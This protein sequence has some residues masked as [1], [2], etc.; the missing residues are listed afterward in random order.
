MSIMI[1]SRVPKPL[2][3]TALCVYHWLSPIIDPIRV[4]K[5]GKGCLRYF[6]D[7]Y[8][9]SRLLNAE[10]IRLVDTYPQVHDHTDAHG[11]DAH[12]F[13]TNG[14]AI[15][16][17]I[18]APP[19][20]HVDIASQVVFANLLSAVMPVVFVDFRPLEAKLTGLQC[21]A[22]S[23]LSLPFAD[24]SI[25]SL[26]CLHVIE[27]VGLG[28]Y[29]DALDPQGTQKAA[30]ELSRI[31]APEGHMFLTTPVG[32]PRLCFNA[33]RIHSP[34]TIREYFSDLDLIELSGVHD[35][36]RFVEG[37]GLSEFENSDYACG[38][39]HFLKRR[40]GGGQAVTRSRLAFHP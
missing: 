34:Q 28:R 10:T 37:V 39:F 19:V 3:K 18:A 26:S 35:D 21:V 11:Y 25:A 16:R 9:Y 33:H 23:L 38:M 17:V 12:Y 5:G 27:H 1:L 4:V 24:Q 22:G 29:G 13:F 32:R 36:G 2:R 20:F 31:L 8:R 15:R 7:W 40:M 14:W 30:R 6:A